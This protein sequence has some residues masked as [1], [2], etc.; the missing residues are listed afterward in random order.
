MGLLDILKGPI[1]GIINAVGGLIDKVSTTEEEK[2]T[3]KAELATIAAALE[4]KLGEFDTKWAEAQRDVIVAEANGH[5]WLQR[6]WRPLLMLF[7]AFLIGLVVFT[8][9]YVNGRQ[10]DH[11]FIMEILSIVK[12]GLGGYVIGRSAEKVAPHVAAVF[13]K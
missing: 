2:L 11:S 5:S 12:I 13:K 1:T 6:N 7:F 8:G 9:G 3:K 10:L 4:V